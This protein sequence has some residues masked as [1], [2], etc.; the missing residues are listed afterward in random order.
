MPGARGNPGT[1]RAGFGGGDMSRYQVDGVDVSGQCCGG[2]NQ[3][4]SQENIQEFEVI[5]NRYDAEYGRAGGRRD[6]CR[7]QVRHEPASRH[8]FRVSRAT[9]T[10]GDAEN[11]ITH[12]VEPFKEKQMGLNGGGPILRDRLFFFASYEYQSRDVT[13]IPRTGFTSFDVAANNGITRHYTTFRGDAPDRP[14]PSAVCAD[15]NVQL[16]AAQCRRR[17]TQRHLERLQPTL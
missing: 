12:R 11:F 10:S 15:F 16:G 7:H 17:R 2:S 9:V 4:Y 6:Q 3:G 5:T 13:A 14:E 1:I 8:G